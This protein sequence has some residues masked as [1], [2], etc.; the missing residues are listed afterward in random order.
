MG[1]IIGAGLPAL[2]SGLTRKEALGVGFGMSGR[3]AVELIIVSIAWEAGLFD[4]PGTV[5]ANLFS[6]LVLMALVTTIVT[7]IGL[8]W[9]FRERGQQGCNRPG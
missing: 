9:L 2:L 7:P 5:V 8:R 4:Y 1:K 6:A 3:G